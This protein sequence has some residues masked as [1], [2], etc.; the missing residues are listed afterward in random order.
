MALL[1]GIKDD[2]TVK[3]VYLDKELTS[4][5]TSGMYANIGVHPSINLANLLAFLPFPDIKFDNWSHTK[6]YGNYNETELRTDIVHRDGGIFQSLQSNN[7]NHNPT[8]ENS[9][10]WMKTS[11]ESLRLKAFLK[12]VVE[13]VK[14]DLNLTKRLVN[15]QFIYETTALRDSIRL[16]PN[17]WA[18]W[19]FEPKGSDYLTIEINQI[20]IK[21]SGTE[22][23]NLYVLNQFRLV[24]TLVITPSDGKL[25]FKDLNYKFSGPG[26]WMFAI[27]ATEVVANN[28]LIDPLTYDGFVCYTANGIGEDIE[29]AN[30]SFGTIGNGLGFNVSCY[31]N[32][33]LYIQNNFKSLGSFIKVAFELK[34]LEMYLHNSNN[35]SNMIK[36]IQ[37][38]KDALIAETKS[39]DMNTVAKR[40]HDEKRKA[41]KAIEKTFD[42]HL[43][44]SDDFDITLGSI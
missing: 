12:S 32:S 3:D 40:Y 16:L 7:I 44:Y 6:T 5:P 19:V 21:K 26:V 2:F 28:S 38:D 8:E 22:P 20:A 35:R 14:S 23:L 27:E 33:D 41:L 34:A 17:N 18:A 42:T 15:N 30:W 10:F 36:L 13:A 11:L 4:L 9:E 43:F 25:D 37:L 39:L 31:L 1:L 29:Q 24:E